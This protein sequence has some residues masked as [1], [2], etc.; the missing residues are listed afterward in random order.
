M[1]GIGA[2]SIHPADAAATAPTWQDAITVPGVAAL[3]SDES[4]V[5][6]IACGAPGQCSAGG[7]VNTGGIVRALLVDQ[8][9]GTWVD[10]LE[11]PGTAALRDS[12]NADARVKSISCTADGECLA[13]GTYA[14]S[15][16]GR[17][18]ATRRIAGTWTN[19]VELPGLAA[20]AVGGM[21]TINDSSCSSAGNCS[22]VGDYYSG[23]SMFEAFVIDLVNDVWQTASDVPGLVAL[24]TK[25]FAALTSVSCPADGQCS[26]TGHYEN[27][28]GVQG[29][30]VDQAGG[31]WG[32]A[33]DIPGLAALNTMGYSLGETISCSSPGDCSVGG[34][35]A[36][37]ISGD[38][39]AFLA[40]RVGGVWGP[41]GP[42]YSGGTGASEVTEISCPADGMCHAVGIG[43]LGSGYSV[44][45]ADRSDGTWAEPIQL[46]GLATLDTGNDAA[47]Y[48]ISCPAPGAC[49]VTGRY[50]AS[51][52][53]VPFVA[54]LA[55]G[56][57]GAAIPI[58]G[59]AGR[60]S[61]VSASGA[62][63]ACPAPTRCVAVG[64]ATFAGA[65]AG[66]LVDFVGASDPEPTPIGP[67]FTG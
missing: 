12:A 22:V 30:V 33:T 60:N 21:L 18:F 26:A 39:T 9:D 38:N 57:W 29:I 34:R 32:N 10:A 4:R 50:T 27:E 13:V 41:A 44:F 61:G 40:D 64:D 37:S 51:T 25:N 55:T 53:Q 5:T 7:Y 11:V 3:G 62:A 42:A 67:A 59:L 36:Q 14:T 17:G 49:A 54:N 52:G 16:G 31:T 65:S 48:S 66:F 24:N 35:Y 45:V 20:L 47:S 8:V 46:P 58:P 2:L 43:Y 6:E 19:A 1:S 15:S 23:P 28:S 56:S 63:V